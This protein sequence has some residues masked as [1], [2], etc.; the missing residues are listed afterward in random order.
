MQDDASEPG[1]A[2]A[3]EAFADRRRE[4]G[5]AQRELARKG[6]ITASSLI[7]FEK[8]RGWPR[9]RTRAA[10]EEQ[11]QWPAGT[12]A[13]I[14]AGGEIPGRAAVTTDNNLSESAMVV[15]ITEAALVNHDVA[16][17][18]LPAPTDPAFAEQVQAI[19]ANLRRIENITARA[20][21]G[22]QGASAVLR[23]LAG[24]RRRYDELMIRAAAAPGATLGQRL[25]TARR[26]ANLSGAEAAAALGVPPEVVSAVEAD[27]PPP[28]DLRSAIEAL[29]AELDAG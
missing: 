28:G 16:V 19:L 20:V 1:I 11:V 13:A 7:H 26:R 25:Y 22:T 24:V 21:R 17:A 9:E 3:G 10:L 2:R 4:L 14:R 8:G 5:I 18:N 12:L 27:E 6:I 23:S 29:I 15:E